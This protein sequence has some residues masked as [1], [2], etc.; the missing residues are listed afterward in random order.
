M[1]QKIE[2]RE[3][4]SEEKRA[5]WESQPLVKDEV[6]REELEEYL[7]R[8]IAAGR[9]EW[10]RWDVGKIRGRFENEILRD[11]IRLYEIA[12][13][14]K[15]GHSALMARVKKASA[16]QEK[17]SLTP[18]QLERAAAQRKPAPKKMTEEQ[19]ISEMAARTSA[20]RRIRPWT[21]LDC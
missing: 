18:E 20:P 10:N 19:M 2:R 9:G 4:T 8:N 6:T 14:R 13:Y 16:S 3:F 7:R 1:M 5:Y 21:Q 11:W 12:H 15:D 17:G